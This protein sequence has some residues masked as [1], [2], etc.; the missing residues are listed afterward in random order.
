MGILIWAHESKVVEFKNKQGK[1]LYFK[2][3]YTNNKA[4]PNVIHDITRT[5]KNEKT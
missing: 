1:S 4:V 5:R 2:N 3:N